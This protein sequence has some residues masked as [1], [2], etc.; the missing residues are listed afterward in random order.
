M[1]GR[2]KTLQKNVFSSMWEL[3]IGGQNQNPSDAFSA[4]KLLEP[5]HGVFRQKFNLVYCQDSGPPSIIRQQ[6][7][8][9]HHAE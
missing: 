4:A 9:H 1:A 7:S 2:L 5:H 3:K 8:F 6:L